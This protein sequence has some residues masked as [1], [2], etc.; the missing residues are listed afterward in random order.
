MFQSNVITYDYELLQNEYLPTLILTLE[1]EIIHL[2]EQAIEYLGNYYWEGQYLQMD[3]PSYKKWSH[4]L[5]T[6][7]KTNNPIVS[8][9]N[10]ILQE[11]VYYHLIVD[12]KIDEML[13]NITIRILLVVT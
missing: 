11:N 10:V 8:D 2:N 6:L 1:G 13:Q 9:F 12:A 3:E 4:L 5:V 7:K